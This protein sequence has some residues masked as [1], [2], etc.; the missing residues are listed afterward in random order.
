MPA[1]PSEA[2]LPPAKRVALVLGAGGLVGVAHHVGVLAALE[3]ELGFRH[4]QADVLI[5][6]SA[7]SAIAAYLASGWST[8]QLM[9]MAPELHRAAPG[10][11]VPAARSKLLPPGDRVGLRG[12]ARDGPGAVV[13]LVAAGRVP[14]ASLPRRPRHDG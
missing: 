4:D 12:G 8:T 3:D 5:G 7:G 14:P 9:E 11:V 1:G 10:P 6:T 2:Q 13:A